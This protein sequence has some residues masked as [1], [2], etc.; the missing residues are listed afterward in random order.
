MPLLNS[1]RAAICEK[2]ESDREYDCS[3]KE[4]D[5]LDMSPAFVVKHRYT[6]P[7][8]GIT[9]E[10]EF[11]AAADASDVYSQLGRMKS[12]PENVIIGCR[13]DDL[14][15]FIARMLPDLLH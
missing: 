5:H 12:R 15:L 11:G 1:K 14:D 2:Y 10:V 4:H 9:A 8:K 6:L 3:K 7:D 13:K